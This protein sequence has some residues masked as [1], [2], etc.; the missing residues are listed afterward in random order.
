MSSS[1]HKNIFS[2]LAIDKE[3]PDH[4]RH[5]HQALRCAHVYALAIIT[6]ALASLGSVS[7]AWLYGEGQQFPAGSEHLQL[8]PIAVLSIYTGHMRYSR[9]H[10][11][12]LLESLRR[13]P[14]IHYQFIHL[15]PDDNMTSERTPLKALVDNMKVTNFN[16]TA[17]NYSSFSSLVE[18]KLKI[19]INFNETWYYKL[20]DFKPTLAYLFPELA[21]EE[22][23]KYWAYAD[24][25]M[26]WGNTSRFAYFFQGQYPIV[27]SGRCDDRLQ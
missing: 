8:P 19:R 21:D 15:F 2:S 4:M 17:L 27:Q 3:F 22:R 14:S 11:K 20:C 24:I 1:S 18:D 9:F 26:I 13:N 23:Y 10:L 7:C 12:I 6:I 5:K 25:D 16:I